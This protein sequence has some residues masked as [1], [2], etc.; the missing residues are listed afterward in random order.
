MNELKDY[1]YH[2]MKAG[3]FYC[4]EVKVYK[5]SP[6]KLASYF[7]SQK[8]QFPKN[9]V[10]LNVALNFRDISFPDDIQALNSLKT[11]SDI[12]S[13]RGHKVV[14]VMG[15]KASL[16]KSLGLQPLKEVIEKTP[17]LLS[18]E[19][20][21]TEPQ[22]DLEKV[23]LV[24]AEPK[25]TVK[26]ET[27]SS[28]QIH[29]IQVHNGTVRGGQTLFADGDLLV[30]GNVAYGAE[31]AAKGSVIVWG[32]LEGRVHAGT[33]EN[34]EIS[35]NS[36]VVATFFNPELISINGIYVTSAGIDEGLNKEFLRKT[37]LVKTDKDNSKLEFF[38]G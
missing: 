1:E 22:V 19:F 7:D 27:L 28:E 38:K 2:E 30:M 9:F 20:G 29:N 35:K 33:S 15:F 25:Q 8:N 26:E 23:E 6:E 13:T 36:H 16:V 37:T 14:G 24:K 11:Y 12:V 31:I 10:N 17:S 32:R 3:K 34:I 21:T 18:G 5:I 4:Q